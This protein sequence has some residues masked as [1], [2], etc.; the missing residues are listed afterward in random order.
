MSEHEELTF[1]EQVQPGDAVAVCEIVTSTGFFHDHEVAVAVELVQ[2]RLEKGLDSGYLFLFAQQSGRT[3]GYSCYG[4]IPC[5][6][7]SYDLYWIAVHDSCRGRG[8][9]KVL[10]KKTEALIASLR[11]RV[12]WV[13]TSGQEKY[14]PTRE[15]Y[16]RFGYQ[17]EAVLNGFYAAGDDKVIY[18]KHLVTAWSKK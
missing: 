12:I 3:V 6:S 5:T 17:E 9:G 11:G 4:E 18:A 13:E 14:L 2:E 10:L 15:F 8:I 16:R 7:G 1:R